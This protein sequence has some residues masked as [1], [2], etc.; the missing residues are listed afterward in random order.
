MRIKK[1]VLLLLLL[2]CI[3]VMPGYGQAWQIA[4]QLRVPL[5]MVIDPGHGGMDGGAS[6]R[7]GTQEKDI[8]PVSYT[9]LDVYKR[10]DWT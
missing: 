4:Q 2:G 8:N 10:Q 7:D 3:F 9:H 6:A 1:F 5:V